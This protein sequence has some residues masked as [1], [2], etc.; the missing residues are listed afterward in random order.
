MKYNYIGFGSY[1]FVVVLYWSLQLQCG[2]FSSGVNMWW[3]IQRGHCGSWKVANEVGFGRFVCLWVLWCWFVGVL[4]VLSGSV[5]G[6][7]CFL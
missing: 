3:W 5:F 4:S 1:F 6:S 7:P 2:H